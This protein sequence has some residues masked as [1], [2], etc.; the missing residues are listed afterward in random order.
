M[1]DITNVFAVYCPLVLEY[2]P[3]LCT[4]QYEKLDSLVVANLDILNYSVVFP[5][6]YFTMNTKIRPILDEN[7]DAFDEPMLKFT[8]AGD[9]GSIAF[10]SS[11]QSAITFILGEIKQRLE[12]IEE[13]IEYRS[14]LAKY[15]ELDD[16]YNSKT[17]H[18][19]LLE[20]METLQHVKF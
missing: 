7:I 16:L 10:F 1:G 4:A 17:S 8:G 14:L 18:E 9:P 11:R 3:V 20:V 15:D 2:C 6:N 19:G 12:K 13:L 5:K